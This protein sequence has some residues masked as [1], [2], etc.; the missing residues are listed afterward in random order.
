MHPI[1]SLIKFFANLFK[2]YTLTIAPLP[3]HCILCVF[4]LVKL[5]KGII[6]LFACYIILQHYVV[7]PEQNYIHYAAGVA[8][9]FTYRA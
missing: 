6:C 4:L 8:L 2:T 1:F 9:K 5:Y 3:V 7:L